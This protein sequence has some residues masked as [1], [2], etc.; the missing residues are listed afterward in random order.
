M[1]KNKPFRG[2]F[3]RSLKKTLKIMRNALILLFI[4]VLQAH[5]IDTYSQNTKL[6]LN[7]S[8][9]ELVSVLDKIENES[10]F[11]FLYNEK[12]LDI[13]CKVSITAEDQLINVILD[14]LFAG[15][16]VKY[17]IIDRKIILAPDYLT[18]EP[19]QKQITGTVTDKNGAPVI[20]A[21]VVVTGTTQG[22]MT[23][24]DG[25][26]SIEV[27]QGAK[28]LTISFIGME[29]QEISIGTLTQ[30]NV[31]MAES[32]IDLEE[33]IV[34]GYGTQKKSDLTGSVVRVS[35]EDKATLANV[36]LSQSLSGTTAG[37][38]V[39]SSGLAGSE[40]NLIIRG[41]TSLSASVKP[42]IVLDGIIFNGSISDI[43]TN[44]V[45]SIDILKDASSAAVYGSRSANGV[46]LIT[47]KKGKTDKPVVSFNMYYGYQDMTN[48]P[49]KV[50]N[51]EQ[52]AIKLV[53]WYWQQSLYAW[54]KTKP[55]SDAGKPVR[56]DVTN[57]DLVAARLRT[58]EE[59][60]NYLA[61]NEI[62][63]I[64]EVTQVAPIQNY[65]LSLS[66][67]S[68]R[69]NYYVSGSYTNEEGILLNDKFT[70]LTLHTKIES[71]ITDWF[72]LGLISSYSYRDYSGLE[73]VLGNIIT[74]SSSQSG[75]RLCSPLADNKIGQPDYDMYLTGEL[76][77]RYPLNNLYIDNSDIRSNLFLVGSGKIT[78]PW[79]K[80]LTY[81]LTYS[82]TYSNR[83]NSTFYPARSPEG[84]AN[85]GKA[86]KNPS[87]ERNWIVN[88]IVSYSRTFGDHAVNATFLYSRENRNGQSS[89]LQAEGFENPVLGYNSM[90]LGTIATNA[91]TA[92]EENSLS[93][94][95]RVN[96]S[97]KNRYLL[98]ATIRRDG[99]SGFGPNNKIA[100]FPSISLG[101]VASDES[102]LSDIKWLYLKLRLSY[103]KNGNQGIGRY[104]SFSTMA[105]NAYVFGATTA[106]G[107][108]P[109]TLG[110]SDLGWETTSSFNMGLDFGFL[111]RRITGSI[112]V[113]KAQTT[114]VL[115]TRAIPPSTGYQNVWANIGAI[116]NKGIELELTTFNLTGNLSW[117]TNFVFSL[118]RDKISKL[119]GGEEDRDIGNSWFIGESIS[120]IYDYEMAGGLWTEE[121]LYSGSIPLANWYPG[122]YKYVDQNRDGLIEPVEDRK[123]I[124]YKTPNY[125]FGINNTLIYKNFSLF[126]FIN[127]IMGGN[128]YYLADNS[129]V[130]N[131]SW[132]SD[133]VVRTNQSAVRPYWTPDNRVDNA[134]G[135]YN[136]PIMT[137]GIYESRSFVRLQDISLAYRFAPG[138]LKTLHMEGCQF[139][140]SAKNPYVWTKWSGWDPE[141]GVNDFPLMRNIILGFR[142]TL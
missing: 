43:N 104:S 5:A 37:V 87:D 126:F 49:M 58:Q 106:I 16:D 103:G 72:T 133:D 15:T 92:W 124:G 94:M 105:S 99:F 38:N 95:G 45:E 62:D 110:N 2:L 66:G 9:S 14:D 117:E 26:Y 65:D 41:Q 89:T 29:T 71:K 47:T 86:I 31:T 122:Q 19:Q 111:D 70:R 4:G 73:A 107:V 82:Y 81:D 121:E 68:D 51:A 35:M 83:N 118:N 25:K 32:A 61:G 33:V 93:Y 109:S 1:K 79:V 115:V 141:I 12:L 80:G 84:S 135:V 139:Y 48:N 3:Y 20:G 30:I 88:N 90:G 24:I 98:T 34:I 96:Y 17:T 39:Q 13:S 132:N 76:Y 18:S 28:S 127:S 55:T 101:W 91:S 27:P 102:F 78:V 112:D 44:D 6:S 60:D 54:Y 120:A 100:T 108:F 136:A 36:N 63:W 40:P 57:R 131:V 140:V 114:D 52:Y 74:G 8:D 130:V 42:L 23:D 113:Y 123:I 142:I 75:A 21:N 67:K 97:F 129:T 138:L 77:M 116:D 69:S 11:F 50:M 59:R 134:T 56:P 137:S 125:R 46:M 128:G 10:E 53:D 85:K 64:K 119:Y 7:F 22:T